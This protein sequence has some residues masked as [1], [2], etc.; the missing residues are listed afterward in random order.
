M[1]R[2]KHSIIALGLMLVV[3]GGGSAVA[4]DVNDVPPIVMAREA[5]AV[6]RAVRIWLK[7]PV[8][9]IGPSAAPS[10]AVVAY[11]VHR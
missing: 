11:V 3:A 9:G 6:T 10:G 7:R 4:A 8:P 5:E 1:A 2:I